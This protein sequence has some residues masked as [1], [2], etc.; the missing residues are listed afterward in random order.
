VTPFKCFFA[1][2]VFFVASPFGL[3]ADHVSLSNGDRVTGKLVKK[4]GENL[5]V[6]TD[7]IG[8]VTIPWKSVVSVSSQ[9]PLVVVL[10][11]GRTLV[12]KVDT[13]ERENKLEVATRTATESVQLE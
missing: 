8:E 13:N 9:E 2:T 12:G 10:P 6:K 5:I 1:V 11:G 4:D 3:H 7:L